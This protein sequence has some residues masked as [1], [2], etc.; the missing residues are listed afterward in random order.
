MTAYCNFC[1]PPKKFKDGETRDS[2]IKRE[3]MNKL[4]RGTAEYLVNEK[5]T[6]LENIAKHF[7][8][9]IDEV[10]KYIEQRKLEVYD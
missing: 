5:G 6:P 7:N 4:T 9:T 3:H 8:T 2:H 10:S 1:N